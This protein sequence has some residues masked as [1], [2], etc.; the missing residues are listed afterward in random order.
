M[1]W[2]SLNCNHHHHHDDD[3]ERTDWGHLKDGVSP[4]EAAV[5]FLEAKQQYRRLVG[6]RSCHCKETSW[7]QGWEGVLTEPMLGL[8]LPHAVGVEEVVEGHPKKL[9]PSVTQVPLTTGGNKPTLK[10]FLNPLY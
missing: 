3:R 7:F 1:I 9:P 4:K 6:L 2:M 5:L 8:Q 10:Q